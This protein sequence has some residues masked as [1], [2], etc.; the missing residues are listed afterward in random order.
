MVTNILGGTI[1]GAARQFQQS[2][3]HLSHSWTALLE[4]FRVFD[5]RGSLAE[6]Q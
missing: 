2:H 5:S 6:S 4:A 1:S 3:C